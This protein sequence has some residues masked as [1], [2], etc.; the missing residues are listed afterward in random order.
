[1]ANFRA[2]LWLNFRSLLSTMR[3]GRKK[4]SYSGLGALAL[5]AGLS[6]Y[7]SGVYS[8]L[9][10]RQLAP[11]GALPLLLVFMSLVAVVLG[12][13]FSL[14]AAQGVIFGAKDNDLMLSLPISPFALMLSRTLA[15][16]LENLVSTVFVLL[17][18]G[19]I[20]L[21]YGGPGGWAVLPLLLVSALFLNLLPT[22]L[23]LII[24]FALAW[25]S[26]RFPR[27]TLATSLLQLLLLALIL[28]G[29][30]WLGSSINNVGNAVPAILA[31]FQGWGRPFL[32]L[33]NG[34][35]DGDPLQLLGLWALCLI[36]FL[37]VTWL[38]AWQYKAI[39]TRMSTHR[40]R[41]DYKLGKLTA[42]G[43]RGA[44][45]RKE[46]RRWIGT[47][48]YVFNTGIGLLLIPGA[49]VAALLNRAAIARFQVMAG[50]LELA[51]LILVCMGFCLSTISITASSISLEG[52][53]IWLLQCAPVPAS[54]ILGIKMAFQLLVTLPCLLVG[55]LLLSLSFALSP[56]EWGVAAGRRPALRP[57]VRPSGAVAQPAL[58]Q[59]GRRQRRGGGQAVHGRRAGHLPAHGV[60][61]SLLPGLALSLG[62]PGL[63]GDP[64]ALCR[65]AGAG[66]QRGLR[67]GAAAGA[68]TLP[69]AFRI[70]T[71]CYNLGVG[72]A[73]TPK[74][75]LQ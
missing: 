75:A 51:P 44:L 72:L 40:S 48:V 6:V 39:I 46:A 19:V 62:H 57:A 11:V 47:P 54:T 18:A 35:S 36:P 55:W 13:F 59:A 25:L 42:A 17:P 20:Y 30:F 41:S 24:G 28:V 3:V 15:L 71:N 9:L 69:A 7:I 53:Q 23:T 1:M 50:G 34:V 63:P 43:Q 56:A 52:K 4:R 49:G 27:K 74:F 70:V 64:G 16:Y 67:P 66:R 12:F 65:R 2:L 45:L 73:P 68:G 10:A 5:V 21:W 38:F 33:A 29:S 31:F 8:S 22:L 58:P 32:M 26:S 60:A 61:H 14:F 37:M